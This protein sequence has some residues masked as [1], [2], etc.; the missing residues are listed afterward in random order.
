LLANFEHR[1][2]RRLSSGRLPID[3]KL[4][5]HGLRQD[6]AHGA[7]LAFLRRA[8]SEHLRHV[9][10]VTGKGVAADDAQV[11]PYSLFDE[12][13]RGVLREQVPRWLAEPAF[14]VLV[15]SFTVAGRGHGGSGALYIQI[16]KR[17]NR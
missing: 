10:I 9:K 14:R 5:L 8:Q 17:T 12:N 4:D 2:A 3:A 16:R 7:L 6:E 1:R 11:R 15:V 13:R